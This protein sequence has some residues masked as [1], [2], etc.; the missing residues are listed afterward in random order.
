MEIPS[1]SMRELFSDDYHG[2][3]DVPM[4]L[5]A[6]AEVILGQDLATRKV[7]VVEGQ[8]T[9]DEVIQDNLHEPVS[10]VVV[11]LD[12]LS[13]DLRHLQELVE[14]AK[15]RSGPSRVSSG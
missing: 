13:D 2:Y 9:L 4:L 7:F 5:L 12:Q 6:D 8:Q 10:V 3:D 11:K 15:G 1:I 14:I